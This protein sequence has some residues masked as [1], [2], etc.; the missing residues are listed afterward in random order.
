MNNY[1]PDLGES[2]R[3]QERLGPYLQQSAQTRSRSKTTT[4]LP[5]FRKVAGCERRRGSVRGAPVQVLF[6]NG[7]GNEMSA[8]P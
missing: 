8:E 3:A 4:P 2:K 7:F 5:P 1:S 6:E